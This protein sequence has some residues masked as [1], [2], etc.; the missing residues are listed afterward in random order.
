MKE[1]A[2]GD[3]FEVAL[4]ARRLL[5]ILDTLLFSGLKVELEASKRRFDWG[6]PIDLIVHL[7]NPTK[8][9]ARVPM[10]LPDDVRRK[11]GPAERQ[12]AD[13]L[14]VAE[15]LT[16]L[17]PDGQPIDLH[18]DDIN[19]DPKVFA[20]VEARIDGGPVSQVAPGAHEVLRVR[21]FNRG[22]ARYRLLR[23]G[24][25]KIQLV[26]DPQWDDEEFRN[27]G[28]GRVT[29]NVLELV[30]E[31]GAPD[32]VCEAT[33]P[34]R[35]RLT[36]SGDQA[37]VTLVNLQDVPVY[38]NLNLGADAAPP[39]AQLRWY[40]ACADVEESASPIVHQAV[41]PLGF[42]H[43]RIKEVPPGGSIEVGRIA[44]AELAGTEFLRKIGDPCGCAVSA[45][46][47]NLTDIIWQRTQAADWLGNPNAP[48]V[49]RKP[50]PRRVL[51][52]R[53]RSNDVPWAALERKSSV[54]AP[55]PG[56]A[57]QP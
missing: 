18:V 41:G 42:S 26:Y 29:S 17:G 40:V 3:D 20:A 54:P 6:E 53:L 23:P 36:R 8:H 38:V 10:E 25:Y 46:Y 43:D 14:D 55:Q 21:E 27:A 34:A 19:E 44:V 56:D 22:W 57:P 12:V 1:A 30:V 4:R 32:I 7:T 35:L 9:P 52:T 47:V 48:N 11:S 39:F 5:F 50:L 13:M 49:L 31:S 33:Q 45:S 2:D 37:V 16:V 28:V 15:Y 24:A 51:A